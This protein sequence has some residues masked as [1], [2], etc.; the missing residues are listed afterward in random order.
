MKV[1]T[2]KESAT[3]L[4]AKIYKRYK[5]PPIQISYEPIST[6]PKNSINFQGTHLNESGDTRSIDEYLNSVDLKQELTTFSVADNLLFINDKIVPLLPP[7]AAIVDLGCGI[8][9][10][11]KIL[12]QENLPTKQWQ[13]L[14]IDRDQEIIKIAQK[15][16]PQYQF[17]SSDNTINIPCLDSSQD[18][19]MASSML[20]YT[21]DLWLNALQE[22]KR[23]T[24]KYIFI[25]R[26]P[27]L[28][29]QC[30]IYCHQIVK[31]RNKIEHHYFK[32]FSLKEFEKNIQNL[33]MSIVATSNGSEIISVKSIREPI[34]LNQYLLAIDN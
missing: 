28:R 21:C 33:G 20:Q 22:M 31:E 6:L 32:L 8:G 17:K 3:S 29:H 27:I 14:G 9:K 24:K 2:K 34:I 11:A 25:S 4:I 16:A 10:Y 23:V 7:S 18:L 15:F 12:Q 1:F 5:S 19:V 13:Y 26:L 30:S